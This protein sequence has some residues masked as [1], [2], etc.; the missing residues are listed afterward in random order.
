M[1]LLIAP[2][3]WQ[4][5]LRLAPPVRIMKLANIDD[6]DIVTDGDVQSRLVARKDVNITSKPR[7]LIPAVGGKWLT[8]LTPHQ[9]VIW[10]YYVLLIQYNLCLHVELH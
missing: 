8:T 5:L 9:K 6:D 1:L 3:K 10:L 4:D 2:G 7:D